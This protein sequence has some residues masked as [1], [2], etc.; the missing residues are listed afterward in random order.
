MAG[1]A[2]RAHDKEAKRKH[3]WG[4]G[5]KRED[6]YKVSMRRQKKSKREEGGM[7]IFKTVY[8]GF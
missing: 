4:E 8:E 3:G 1:N 2:N 6:G 7:G 5:T